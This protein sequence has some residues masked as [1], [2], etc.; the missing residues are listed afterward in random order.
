MGADYPPQKIEVKDRDAFLEDLRLAVYASCLAAYVQGINIIDKSNRERH[1]NINFDQ[2]LQIWRA[3]CI[4]QADYISELLEPIFDDFKSK[5]TMNLLFQPAT[6]KD[7]KKGKPSLQ[8]IVADAVKAD[9]VVPAMSATLEYIKYQTGHGEHATADARMESLLTLLI[10][11]P[12]ILLRGGAR[13][14][15]PSHVRQER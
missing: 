14:F 4:I 13:L 11:S 1:W 8:R 7:L 9:H 15:R 6:A 12:H 5:D 2:V 10:R 3:G